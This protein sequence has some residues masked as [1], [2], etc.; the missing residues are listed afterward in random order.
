MT[1]DVAAYDEYL[2]AM[3]L[4]LQV[5][6]PESIPSVIA[7]LQRAVDIDPQFSMAW[8]GLH[9]VFSTGSFMFPER[10]VEWRRAASESLERARQLTPDAPHVLLALG[11]AS[12]RGGN[13]LEGADLFKRLE[14]SHARYMP[15]EVSAPRGMLLLAVGRIDEAIPALESRRAHE[16]LAPSLANAL[17]RAYLVNGNYR[18]ALAEIDRGLKLAGLHEVLLNAAFMTALNIGD[19][20]EMERRLA[21]ITDETPTVRLHRRLAA[22]LGKPAG[23]RGGDPHTFGHGDLPRESDARRLGGVLRRAGAR[24][25]AT[26]RIDAAARADPA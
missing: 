3:A 13:W 6:R 19:R 24:A 20:Q 9:G 12:M 4:N 21:A 5:G 25:R 2:R 18:G 8:S 22:F 15:G 26:H 1:R 17:S 10:A 23:R 7:H 11:I 16:P 14:Q